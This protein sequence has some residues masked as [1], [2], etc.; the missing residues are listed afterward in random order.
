METILSKV[1][2]LIKDKNGLFTKDSFYL[3]CKDK[4]KLNV[5]KK[6]TD[7]IYDEYNP[8]NNNIEFENFKDSFEFDQD[9]L[10]AVGL[11]KTFNYF[12]NNGF[13]LVNS[14]NLDYLLDNL[15]DGK[16]K[17]IKEIFFEGETKSITYNEFIERLI[18]IIN[19][20]N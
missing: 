12:S 10:P 16:G 11:N 9:G 18:F 15:F 8:E 6:Y 17:T 19:K 3:T 7:V 5:D 14:K 1:F 20:L 13:T 2:N 4:L